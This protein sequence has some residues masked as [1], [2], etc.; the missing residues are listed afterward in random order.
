MARQESHREDILAEAI[1]LV[2][3]IEIQLPVQ[4]EPMVIGFRR[5][6]EVSVY[7]GQDLAYHFNAA[8]QL[9]RGFRDGELL[10]ADRGR[11]IKLTRRRTDTETQLVRRELDESET[12]QFL[13]QLNDRL[14]LLREPIQ[15]GTAKVLRQVPPEADVRSRVVGWLAT[16]PETIAVARHPRVA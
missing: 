4:P 8:G 6:G 15:T 14:A 13:L 9:R 12:V 1:A 10:K 7:F 3:R 5:G 16:L 11:L 2:E